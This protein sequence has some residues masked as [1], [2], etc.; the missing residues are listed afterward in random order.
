LIEQLNKHSEENKNGGVDIKIDMDVK[1]LKSYLL[2]PT[3]FY[4]GWIVIGWIFLLFFGY[5]IDGLFNVSIFIDVWLFLS[6]I[7]IFVFIFPVTFV[8]FILVIIHMI[9]FWRENF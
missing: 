2:I 1:K 3:T 7:F 4:T 8:L 9:K 5:M 6:S